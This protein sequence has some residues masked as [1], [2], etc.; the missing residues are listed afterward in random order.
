M[1]N[2]RN[3]VKSFA[4]ILMFFHEKNG[5]RPQESPFF[6]W[7]ASCLSLIRMGIIELLQNNI[8][9]IEITFIVTDETFVYRDYIITI[10]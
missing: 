6:Y 5:K 8:D 3:G 7:Q 4:Y 9:F 10:N 2:D 1:Q